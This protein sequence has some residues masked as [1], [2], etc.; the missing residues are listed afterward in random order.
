[1]AEL[2]AHA[3]CGLPASPFPSLNTVIIGPF[4]DI[5]SPPPSPQLYASLLRPYLDE[6]N[7]TVT[8]VAWSRAEAGEFTVCANNRFTLA[9]NNCVPLSHYPPL[10][11]EG[12]NCR[13][14]NLLRIL[15]AFGGLVT[16]NQ[17]TQEQI[18]QE[19]LTEQRAD[20]WLLWYD[21]YDNFTASR[22]AARKADEKRHDSEIAARAPG[23]KVL[24]G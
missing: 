17:L 14:V 9:T 5:F 4:L 16:D 15:K 2:A 3:D 13:E 1:M 10:P 12:P 21:W 6:Q 7:V 22:E 8:S 20:Q 18:T 19:Q 24:V 23:W 11:A